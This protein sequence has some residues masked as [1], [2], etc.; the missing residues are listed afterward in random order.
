MTD[1][2]VYLK[3]FFYLTLFLQS[4]P[5]CCAPK[6]M[7]IHSVEFK[8]YGKVQGVFFRKYTAQQANILNLRGWCENLPDGTVVGVIEGEEKSVAE[9]KEWLQKTGSPLSSITKVDFKELPTSSTYRFQ[10]FSCE[11]K[12]ENISEV[13]KK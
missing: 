1:S 7:S 11:N 2:P 4:N 3:S 8:V 6:K 13:G 10:S 5:S 9:M 12:P